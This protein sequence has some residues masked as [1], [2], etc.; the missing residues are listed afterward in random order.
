M[1]KKEKMQ[2]EYE[3]ITEMFEYFK[4]NKYDSNNKEAKI[5]LRNWIT[6]F[7][8]LEAKDIGYEIELIIKDENKEIDIEEIVK[9]NNKGI[10]FV[11]FNKYN[12]PHCFI[13]DINPNTS[14]A[15]M[16]NEDE[17]DFALEE[18]QDYP[19]ELCVVIIH[20]IL[21]ELKHI[22][23]YLMAKTGVSSYASLMYAKENFII[24]KY[25]KFYKKNHDTM[26]IEEDA[27]IESAKYWVEMSKQEMHA[28]VP[29]GYH[30][31]VGLTKV[32][33]ED[34]AI[35]LFDELANM[36]QKKYFIK[37]FPILQKEYNLDGSKKTAIELVNNMKAEMQEI[38]DTNDLSD[39]EKD[40]LIA[41]CKEMYFEILYRQM[42]HATMEDINNI[43]KVYNKDYKNALVLDMKSF[44]EQ[45]SK[46]DEENMNLYSS[47]QEKD[48]IKE[49]NL[50]KKYYQKRIDFLSSLEQQENA[51]IFL[52]GLI[53]KGKSFVRTNRLGILYRKLS[54]ESCKQ[55]DNEEE[56]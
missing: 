40:I 23:S 15:I 9:T 30:H 14:I 12:G 35:N 27:D 34:F 1:T 42:E 13:G 17:C 41:D 49:I 37:C 6:E 8:R 18:L 44:F 2:K 55:N 43:A 53:N 4:N 7:I 26:H 29:H 48:K 51:K 20:G 24:L 5:K 45:K 32:M 22:R 39:D 54:I 19:M 52:S 47:L 28:Q 11:F 33:R 3:I 31:K 10:L 56:R 50:R 38:F 21:H 36:N 16:I 25:K 46:K